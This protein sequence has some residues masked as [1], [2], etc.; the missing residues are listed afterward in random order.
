MVFIFTKIINF[1]L[2]VIEWAL[3]VGFEVFTMLGPMVVYL[4]QYLIMSRN[5]SPG[6]FSKSV[7]YIMIISSFLRIIFW[8]GKNYHFS[9]FI[10]SMVML[11]VQS[12]MLRKYFEVEVYRNS[13]GKES[14]E[15]AS[16]IANKRMNDLATKLGILFMV[17]FAIFMLFMNDTFVEVTG[18]LSSVVEAVVPL[19][20]FFSNFQRK[21]VEGV[22]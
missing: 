6:S 4:P 13:G 11:I 14:E 21:S 10:Q 7:C 15:D 19:P 5:K 18:A 22:R 3:E 2:E 12:V 9:L 1:M 20:Q 8:F 16:L 17:Y